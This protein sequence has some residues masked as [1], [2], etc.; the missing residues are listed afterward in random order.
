[1]N[2]RTFRE[3]HFNCKCV[4]ARD[5]LNVNQLTRDSIATEN[6]PKTIVTLWRCVIRGAG[7][8][9][10]VVVRGRVR[11]ANFYRG[12][13]AIK[14]NNRN[15]QH[16]CLWLFMRSTHFTLNTLSYFIALQTSS[17]VNTKVPGPGGH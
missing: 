2:S 17:S 9:E 5:T 3:D 14:Q 13:D 6:L 16:Q 7:E 12:A 4:S 10:K 1:M 11:V 8:C 15:V